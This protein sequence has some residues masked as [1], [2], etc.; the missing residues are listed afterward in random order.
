MRALVVSGR[1]LNVGGKAV[2][3]D[4]TVRLRASESRGGAASRNETDGGSTAS[5][6]SVRGTVVAAL[7]AI[8]SLGCAAAIGFASTE[9]AT[10]PIG[11]DTDQRPPTVQ[12]HTPLHP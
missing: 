6:P 11:P 3:G 10:G 5:G 9:G 2:V 7:G 12:P 1:D 4:N 8:A